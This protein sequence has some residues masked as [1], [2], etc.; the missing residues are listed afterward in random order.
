MPGPYKYHG[1]AWGVDADITDPG[2]Y[3]LNRHGKSQLPDQNPGQYKGKHAGHEMA[4]GLSHGPCT[5]EVHAM[6][7]DSKG[8]FRTEITATLQNLVVDGKVKFSVDRVTLGIVSVYRRRWYDRKTPHARRTRVLPFECKLQ[9]AL[10]DGKPLKLVLPRPFHYS[11]EQREDYLTKDTPNPKMDAEVRAAIA[12]SPSR[13]IYVPN[14]GRIFYGE[15]TLLP[16]ATWN[17]IHQ[18]AMVR[19]AFGSPP[20]GGG[21]GPGGQGGGG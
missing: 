3:R 20:S 18:I 9:N 10:I 21:T 5:T 19:M 13:S 17:T 4:G 2:P 1:L 7:E 11:E 12:S 16:G 6:P 15:W 8:F 14:F